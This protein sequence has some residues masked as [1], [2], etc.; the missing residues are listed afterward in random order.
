[1]GAGS[2]IFGYEVDG[3][4]YRFEDG[5]PIPTCTDGAVPEIEILGMGLATNIEADHNV[6]GET[7]YI[8]AADA[9]F[10]AHVLFREVTAETLDACARGNGMIVSWRRGA[11]EIFTA[12]TCEWV[13]G[14]LRCDGQVEQITRNV[15]NKF[16][17][18]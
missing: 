10:K 3:L 6:W 5:L 7:L 13:A 12:A 1:L 16:G 9:S 15:L 8:G 17:G 2:R 4:D 18:Q 14:L 11:G